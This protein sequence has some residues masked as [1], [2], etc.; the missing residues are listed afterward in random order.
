L[1]RMTHS[2]LPNEAQCASH[3]AGWAHY[4]QRLAMAASGQ[5]P[6]L[7]FFPESSHT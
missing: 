3:A 5:D 1:L 2:G 6:G 7:D 4:I